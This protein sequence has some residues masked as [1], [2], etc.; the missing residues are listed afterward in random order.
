[1]VDGLF[2]YA[3]YSQ[4]AEEAMPISTNRS[5]NVRHWCGGG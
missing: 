4:G 2:F 5:G 1:M 3:P